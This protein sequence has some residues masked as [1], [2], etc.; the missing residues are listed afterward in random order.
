MNAPRVLGNGCLSCT[1]SYV[2]DVEASLRDVTQFLAALGNPHRD[3]FTVRCQVE[4]PDNLACLF[5]AEIFALVD[6]NYVMGF[7]RLRGDSLLFA[8]VLRDYRE[9]VSTGMLPIL[10]PGELI[11]RCRLGPT[12]DPQ[13]DGLDLM[14]P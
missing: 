1:A 5:K 10:F 7:T 8:H 13:V 9:Y 2:S 4:H 11:P 14:L 3:G 12:N 6:G